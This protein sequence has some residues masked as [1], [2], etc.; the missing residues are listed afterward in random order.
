MSRLHEGIGTSNRVLYTLRV[1]T[2]AIRIFD[3]LLDQYRVN[4]YLCKL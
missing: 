2:N 3:K 1:D 4:M